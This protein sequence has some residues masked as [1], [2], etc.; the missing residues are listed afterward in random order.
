MLYP[1]YSKFIPSL[2]TYIGVS[3]YM[4]FFTMYKLGYSFFSMVPVKYGINFTAAIGIFVWAM[5]QVWY[6]F[7]N[8]K[9]VC[10]LFEVH[11]MAEFL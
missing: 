7:W 6:Y 10:G 9:H 2:L 4:Q 1:S 5:K 11:V 8:F 3:M